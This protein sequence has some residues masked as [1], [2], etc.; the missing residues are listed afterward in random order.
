MSGISEPHYYQAKV[1]LNSL[2]DAHAAL[3][4]PPS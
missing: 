2:K 4:Y 3:E 1:F